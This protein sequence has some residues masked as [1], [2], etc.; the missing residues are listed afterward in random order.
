MSYHAATLRLLDRPMHVSAAAQSEIAEVERRLGVR[1]PASVREWYAFEDGAAILAEHSNDDPPVEV[2]NFVV[3]EAEA[4]R[5]LPIRNENQGVC[6][7]AVE[8]DAS[9]DPCVWVDVAA[10]GERWCRSATSFSVYVY[11]CIWDY[12]RVLKREAIVQARSRRLSDAA[13]EHLSRHFAEEPRTYGWPGRVQYRF[14]AGSAGILIWAS[15]DQTDWFI[16]AETEASL[17]EVVS[18]VGYLDGFGVEL[19]DGGI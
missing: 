12:R 14:G 18:A 15:E 4:R 19:H 1:L 6:V 5:L 2:R 7:W 13:L 11:T 10:S 8:I 17:K 9:D 16:A 3:L